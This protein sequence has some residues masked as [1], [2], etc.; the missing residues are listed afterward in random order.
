[1]FG[2]VACVSRLICKTEPSTLIWYSSQHTLKLKLVSNMIGVELRRMR[3]QAY[4]IVSMT[5]GFCVFEGGNAEG[6][7]MTT[8]FK[9]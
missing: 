8:S 9:S 7:C 6:D 5:L 1:M 2:M 3:L 4:S